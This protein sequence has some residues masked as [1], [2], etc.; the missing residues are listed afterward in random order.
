MPVPLRQ[1]DV[2]PVDLPQ[3]F[4]SSLPNGLTRFRLASVP[5]LWVL[6]LLRETTWLGVGVAVAALTDVLDGPLARRLRRTTAGGSRLDSIADHTLT[7]SLVLWLVWLRP[8]FFV[9]QYP[10]LAAWAAVGLT[11]LLVGWVRFRRIGDL[12]L[13]S[14]KVAG[15]VGYLFAIW[16]LLFGTYSVRIFYLV[17]G[18]CIL[19]SAETLLVVSTRSRVSEHLGS[20]F[21]R[22]PRTPADGTASPSRH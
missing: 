12:H 11:A 3:S 22:S 20:I 8:E 16:L 5:F 21:L 17:I 6:A 10:L 15:T 18:I 7:A 2:E 19:A 9:Q 14:A 13:Y 4:W 1:Q